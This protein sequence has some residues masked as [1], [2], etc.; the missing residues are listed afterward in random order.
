MIRIAF[1]FLISFCFSSSAWVGN[2][3]SGV[4]INSDADA[5]IKMYHSYGKYYGQVVWMKDPLDSITGKPQ[6]DKLN[7]DPKLRSRA[8]MNLLVVQNLSFDAKDQ[9][10]SGGTIYNPKSGTSYDMSVKMIDK[11]KLEVL[12]YVKLRSVGKTVYWTRIK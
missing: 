4:W 8:V 7:K 11:Q 10:W 1:F 2:D 5:H 6:L 3:I 12:F 9:E